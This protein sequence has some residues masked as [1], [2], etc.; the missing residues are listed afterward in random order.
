MVADQILP[1]VTDEFLRMI[2]NNTIGKRRADWDDHAVADFLKD[3]GV[4][5]Q[6]PNEQ[7]IRIIVSPS[8]RELD[9]KKMLHADLI[10]E[11]SVSDEFKIIKSRYGTYDTFV[12]RNQTYKLIEALSISANYTVELTQG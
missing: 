12:P 8:A 6:T 9:Y 1:S 11:E 5:Q 10:L 3:V 4:I 7:T 2:I